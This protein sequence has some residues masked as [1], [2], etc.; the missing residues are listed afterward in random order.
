MADPTARTPLPQLT[1]DNEFFWKSGADG[2]LRILRCQ[3]CS[4]Y[5]HPPQP[6]CRYCMSDTF[7]SR[8]DMPGGYG[9]DTPRGIRRSLPREITAGG[10]RWPRPRCLATRR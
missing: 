6:A 2:K 8:S 1:L 3:D 7:A 5:I 10:T 4:S 9:R